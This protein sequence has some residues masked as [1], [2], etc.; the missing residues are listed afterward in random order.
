MDEVDIERLKKIKTYISEAVTTAK[1]ESPL[2]IPAKWIRYG[3]ILEALKD[4]TP[5]LSTTEIL[6]II[7]RL[8]FEIGDVE[9]SDM[10][11][12]F[13]RRGKIL[14]FS[15]E[16]L[17]EIVILDVPWF[18]KCFK[19]IVSDPKHLREDHREVI[20]TVER[21]W[22][23]YLEKGFLEDELY[24][25]LIREKNP[26]LNM[27][28]QRILGEYQNKLGMM[29]H[30]DNFEIDNKNVSGWYVPCVN[31]EKFSPKEKLRTDSK[32]SPI[33]CF[34]FEQYLPYDL[35]GRLIVKCLST[36]HWTPYGGHLYKTGAYMS[37]RTEGGKEVEVCFFTSEK[38]FT[39][40]IISLRKDSAKYG[41]A[42]IT[43]LYTIFEQFLKTFYKSLTKYKI[44]YLCN[45]KRGYEK[46]SH[47]HCI[48]TEKNNAY[49]KS[50]DIVFKTEMEK[51]KEFWE[52]YS[53]K[54]S[55][56]DSTRSSETQ[57]I[58]RCCRVYMEVLYKFSGHL[59]PDKSTNEGFGTFFINMLKNQMPYNCSPQWEILPAVSENNIEADM[60]RLDRLIEVGQRLRKIQED[61]YSKLQLTQLEK[62]TEHIAED[63]KKIYLSLRGEHENIRRDM[64]FLWTGE[65]DKNTLEKLKDIPLISLKVND[66]EYGRNVKVEASVD[67]D[68]SY[69]MWLKSTG[70]HRRFNILKD[71]PNKIVIKRKGTKLSIQIQDF[72]RYDEGFYQLVVATEN[73]V[74][75]ERFMLSTDN[76]KLESP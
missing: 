46:D 48:V 4:D 8:N 41:H 73:A 22:K 12:F 2:K 72:S 42:I 62:E 31:T 66:V 3:Y 68:I 37:Y 30:I 7:D 35:F 38:V 21:K 15:V 69:V 10:L 23:W 19:H 43:E 51:A 71:T 27:E 58:T 1:R 74:G 76:E 75:K 56:V 16:K 17:R 11:E 70:L 39:V 25:I 14:Y 61:V 63:L 32:A 50:C 49:C 13:H 59:K 53:E 67:V 60:K 44:G 20:S 26:S 24:Q 40:Q 5:V 9:I 57:L 18:V 36:T 54:K 47:K 6:K 52:Q 45:N 65:E 33:L 34:L 28:H 64:F 55:A 29:F